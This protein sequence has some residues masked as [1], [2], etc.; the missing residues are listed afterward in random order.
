MGHR[1]PKKEAKQQKSSNS[2]PEVIT[3]E[4]IKKSTSKGVIK[5]TN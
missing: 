5:G 2:K 4:E 1:E 3:P